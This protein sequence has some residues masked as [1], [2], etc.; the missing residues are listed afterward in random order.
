MKNFRKLI[1]IILILELIYVLKDVYKE[2]NIRLVEKDSKNISNNFEN[3]N[4]NF[5]DK[6]IESSNN[7]DSEGLTN[8]KTIDSIDNYYVPEKYLGYEVD[9]ILEIPKINLKTYVLKKYSEDAMNICP[10]KL[11][12]PEPNNT[13]NYSIIG[14]NYQKENMF[15]NLIELNLG[16]EIFLTDNNNGENKYFVYDIY[17]VR[18]DNIEP[19]KQSS[20]N[21]MELTLITC[22]NYTNNRLIVKARSEK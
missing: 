8:D 21:K 1:L 15:N 10:T 17:K 13:G 19:I 9:G 7:Y 12:G 16:D 22:V 20:D 14:H 4:Q 3:V 11:W 6:I 2:D 5:N 18:E